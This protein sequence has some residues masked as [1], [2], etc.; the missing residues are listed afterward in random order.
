MK[1]TKKLTFSAVSVALGIVFMLLGYF[2]EMLDLTA[3][4]MSSLVMVFVYLE[5]GHPYTYGVWII[6]SLLAFLFYQGSLLWIEYFLVFGI[7]PI[8]KGYIERLPRWS[9][10]PL[11]LLFG[12]VACVA[13]AL[14]SHF[15]LAMPII[16][17]GEALL[18]VSGTALY[19]IFGVVLLLAFICYDLF[20][21]V[22]VRF[23]LEKIRPKLA[24]LLK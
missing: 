12:G 6:T 4:A 24:K 17:E 8:I 21:N 7:Y 20:I 22:M 13:F 2:L 9:W 10:I 23:Y 16:A 1:L 19:I 11:K 18:G 14:F 5:V 15:V 3:A